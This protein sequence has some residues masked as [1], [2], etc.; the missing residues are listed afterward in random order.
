MSEGDDPEVPVMNIVRPIPEPR[1][2][3][4]PFWNAARSQR[5]EIQRCRDCGT[6]HHPPIPQCQTCQSTN[7]GWTQVSGRGKIYGYTVMHQPL[8]SGFEEA[9]PYTCVAV[10][11]DEQAGLLLVTN[12]LGG[13]SAD[14]AVGR[15]V[16][17]EF[18]EIDGGFRLPQFRMVPTQPTSSS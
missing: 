1:A 13:S 4:A 9:I 15:I 10:E 6:Y 18:E 7:L 14:P 8:V 16:E 17:V 11:L 3:T 5:L 12:L 2:L